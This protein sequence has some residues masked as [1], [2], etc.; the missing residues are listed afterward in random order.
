[1]FRQ[2]LAQCFAS[3]RL[4]INKAEIKAKHLFFA[5]TQMRLRA[6]NH[7]SMRA[8][9][10]Y[11]AYITI[12]VPILSHPRQQPSQ[13]SSESHVVCRKV[14]KENPLA[15]RMFQRVPYASVGSSTNGQGCSITISSHDVVKWV[16][17][18]QGTARLASHGMTSARAKSTNTKRLQICTFSFFFYFSRGTGW[19]GRDARKVN[20]L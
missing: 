14:A 10:L 19:G 4:R 11:F 5:Q 6:C 16:S 13:A 3:E 2:M 1:M 17:Y 20:L 18:N 7:D 9:P 15:Q 12:H 8:R